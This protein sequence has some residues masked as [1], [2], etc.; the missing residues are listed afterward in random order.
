M[1]SDS[2]IDI[3]IPSFRL[4]ERFIL[5]LVE[6]E[7]PSGWAFHYYLV[8][9]N[10][11][12]VVAKSIQQLTDNGAVTLLINETNSGASVSRNRG[13]EAG[14][15]AWILFLD[16]DIE[17]DSRLLF[18][19]AAAVSQQPDALGFIGLTDF[20]APINA[21]TQA[22]ELSGP[23]TPFKIATKT[24]AFPWGVTA[25][26][27]FNRRLLGAARFSADFPKNG[28][29]EDV[30]LAAR[31]SLKYQQPFRCLPEAKVTHPW[32]NAG[33][34]QYVRFFRYGIG[35]AYLLPRFRN[36]VWYGFPNPVETLLAG[37]VWLPLL[38]LTIGWGS[39]LVCLLAVP[40]FEF[41]TQFLRAA[42]AG[43]FRI[44]VVW[45]MMMVRAAND[46]GV[47]VGG[48]MQRRS[49]FMKRLNADFT[50]PS[51]FRL[52]RYRIVKLVLFVLLIA[53]ISWRIF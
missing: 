47:L 44:P 42:R 20:P 6:L 30:D 53:T 11:G 35:T 13:M 17:P 48:R 16:D 1:I 43:E 27:L 24:D 45:H 9:D 12:V 15:G 2:S 34:A 18:R 38:G 40:V 46:W 4:D 14:S 33:K 51:H 41:F 26:M 39:A 5:P 52:N 3:V 36:Y 22:V 32:W 37:V 21:F 8:V 7:K 29:G 49:T 28:G 19:Y 10:P 50:T 23:L 25:N 31:L